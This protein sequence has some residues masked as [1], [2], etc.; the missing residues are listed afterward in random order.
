MMRRIVR[1]NK[2]SMDQ[3]LE[4]LRE[5]ERAARN[6]ALRERLERTRTPEGA[7]QILHGMEGLNGK[8]RAFASDFA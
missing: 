4:Q 8:E 3:V 5:R 7:L 1:M 2:L 6:A